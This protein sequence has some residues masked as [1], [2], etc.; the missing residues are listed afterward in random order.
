MKMMAAVLAG[1]LAAGAWA[2]NDAQ[3]E[4]RA[5]P[6]EQKAPERGSMGSVIGCP[7]MDRSMMGGG[8]PNEQWRGPDRK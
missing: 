1:L 6:K 4:R 8:K 2:A 7:M 3:I 5:E